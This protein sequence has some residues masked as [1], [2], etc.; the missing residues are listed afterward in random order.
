LKK[1]IPNCAAPVEK[2]M[3]MSSKKIVGIGLSGGIDS[4]VAARLLLDRGYEVRAFTLDFAGEGEVS[5][6]VAPAQAIAKALGISHTVLQANAEFEKW[7]IE[8]FVEDYACGRT[9][10]PCVRCNEKVK[11]GIMSHAASAAGCDFIATGHYADIQWNA[12]SGRYELIRGID[13]MK[14][15]SYFLAR[16]TQ[17][18]LSNVLFPLG[19]K[20][21]SE[22]QKYAESLNVVFKKQKESQDLCFIPDGHFANFIEERRPDLCVEGWIVDSCG[23]KLGKHTG[24]FQYTRGQRRGLGLGG[25][26][27]FVLESRLNDNTVVVGRNEDLMSS[28]I[29]IRDVVCG[30]RQL[31]PGTK[32]D[33]QVQVRYRMKEVPAVLEMQDDKNA[34]LHFCSPV[35]AATLGQQAVCYLEKAVLASGWIEKI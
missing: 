28:K 14:D 22:I 3:M 15:Q 4:F 8:P 21:K 12:E 11:F 6:A 35:M 23:K 31:C 18:Q 2:R 16:L 1:R 24:A 34:I 13:P 27:W 9:P 25:G 32:I 20:L 7:I 26:P 29:Y 17:K 30:A 19:K 5:E 33:C 10:S